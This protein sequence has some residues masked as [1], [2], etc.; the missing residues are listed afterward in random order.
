MDNHSEMTAEGLIEGVGQKLE[1]H[2]PPINAPIKPEDGQ[3]TF[4]FNHAQKRTV[5]VLVTVNFGPPFSISADLSSEMNESQVHS[6]Q[7][8]LRRVHETMVKKA[9][10]STGK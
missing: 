5:Q 7:E 6:L 4:R 8:W 10:P 1:P 2:G 9:S 3:W